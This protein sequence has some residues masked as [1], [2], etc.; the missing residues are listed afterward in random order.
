MDAPT[1]FFS[2]KRKHGQRKLIH[3]LLSDTGQ[4]LTEPEQIRRRAIEF[5]TSL[6][7]S[8]FKDNLLDTFSEELPQVSEETNCHLE[9]PLS[10]QE[11]YLALQSMQGQR[12]PG[13]DG[14][15]CGFYKA[16]FDILSQDILEV[17]N[18]SL[19]TSYRPLFCRRVPLLPE[20]WSLQDIRNWRPVSLLCTDYKLLSKALAIEQVIY[21][22]QTYCVP[23]RSMVVNVMYMQF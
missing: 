3:S 2:L 1:N 14:L 16:F 4:E 17:F 20:K 11:L 5:Y 8:N 18:E 9:C 23:S 7:K 19:G 6:Y 12:A 10:T 13:I 22:D 21:R 15:T